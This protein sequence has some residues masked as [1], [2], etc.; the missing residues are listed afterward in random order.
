MST[1]GGL[2]HRLTTDEVALVLRRAAELEA[3]TTGAD[4]TE[5]FEATVVMDAAEEVGLSPYTV[6]Q[7]L[8]E[9]QTGTLPALQPVPSTRALLVGPSSVVESRMVACPPDDVLGLVD[10]Y[11]RRRSFEQRR[12]QDLWVV[13]RERRDVWRH[14]RRVVDFDG[15]RQL[16]GVSAVVVTVSPMAGSGSMVR[17]EATLHPGWRGIPFTATAYGVLAVTGTV[18]V[19]AG[20]P[21]ALFVGAPV[22]AAIGATGWERRRR[23]RR[24][25]S[26]EVSEVLAALL[27]RLD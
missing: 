9:L 19:A 23:W 2:P 5:G 26:D 11:F 6:R 14:V 10:Q 25:R 4:P 12:R 27:D 18:A 13:Y 7:A 8:G 15:A 3:Q 17:V 24:R 1:G 21:A 22:G 20:D 16:L